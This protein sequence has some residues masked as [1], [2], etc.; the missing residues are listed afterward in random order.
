M[1]RF[2]MVPA[3]LR[4]RPGSAVLAGVLLVAAL[5]ASLGAGYTVA[6]PLLRSG[7][8]NV[9]K[10]DTVAHL[11]GESGTFEAEAYAL[12]TGGGPVEVVTLHDGR[13]AVVDTAHHTVRIIG[14]PSAGGKQQSSVTTTGQVAVV[15]APDAGYVVDVDHGKVTPIAPSG[16]P[17]GK[18][19]APVSVPNATGDAV[20]DGSSG[21]WVRTSAGQAA[22]VTGGGQTTVSAPHP[23]VA[24]TTAAGRPIGLADDRLLYD[25]TATPPRPLSGPLPLGP[26]ERLRLA[27]PSGAGSWVSI[28]DTANHALVL[29][30]PAS[31]E[32]HRYADLPATNHVLG[33]PAQAGDTVYVPDF[34]THSLLRYQ[35][36]EGRV[37]PDVR[38]PGKEPTFSVEVRDGRV[39]ANDQYD[40]RT[41]LIGPGGQVTVVDKGTGHGV[42]T[43]TEAPPDQPAK[44]PTPTPRGTDPR[45]NQ[46]RQDPGGGTQPRQPGGPRTTP[47]PPPPEPPVAVPDIPAGTDLDAAC[48]RIVDAGLTCTRVSAGQGGPTN[49]VIDTNPPAGTLVQKGRPV[50]VRYY[51][52][53]QVPDVVGLPVRNA[54]DQITQVVAAD[55]T[56]NQVAAAGS[57]LDT[58]GQVSAQNPVPNTPADTGTQVTV[59]FWNTAPL[60]DYRGRLDANAVC[61]EI[62]QLTQNQVPCSVAPGATTVASGQPAN[63]VSSQDPPAGTAVGIGQ[64][65]VVHA[66]VQ[67]NQVPDL[68]NMT[69]DA[70]NAALAAAGYTPDPRADAFTRT[71]GVVV[72]Q[73]TPAGTPQD[74]GAVAYHYTTAAP[75]AINL[76]TNGDDVWVMR[77]A[78]QPA[79]AGYTAAGVIGYAYGSGTGLPP[80]VAWGTVFSYQ[81]TTSRAACDGHNPN[82]YYSRAGAPKAGWQAGG[83]VLTIV[84][85]GAGGCPAPGMNTLYRNWYDSGSTRTYRLEAGPGGVGNELLGCVW[86]P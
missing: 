50:R 32:V 9:A 51:G 22:H 79:P 8:A 1:S 43:D 82:H 31:G 85:G 36:R 35:V 55:F 14:S 86:S 5:G 49:T 30:D 2:S 15:S 53:V 21:I 19:P 68:T 25:L 13:V 29:V 17:A 11:N 18:P 62:A 33:P 69:P 45:V 39:W 71:A 38:V 26:P 10:G 3:R 83:V 58:L 80:G 64:A 47:P 78:N 44:T 67:S 76:Y 72:A 63:S 27:G 70:A 28:V 60:P 84:N 40:R 48:Q 74:G 37:R 61:T 4:G 81:C 41:L 34:A 56:C 75:I 12:A 77:L 16:S 66:V 54:C 20:P 65:V 7:G 59:N 42:R 24:L 23:L 46:P 57:T 6:H 73:D 52:Q